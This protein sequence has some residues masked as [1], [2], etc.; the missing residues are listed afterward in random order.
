MCEETGIEFDSWAYEYLM[1]KWYQN[2]NRELQAVQPRD[3]LKIIQALCDYEGSPA[4]LTPELI[5]EACFSYFV[6]AEV[7]K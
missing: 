4:K 3:L 6:G 5:D 2:Q 7:G 1:T